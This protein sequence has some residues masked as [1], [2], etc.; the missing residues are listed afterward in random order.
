MASADV[1]SAT[2][3]MAA[4]KDANVFRVIFTDG[5]F[6]EVN[7]NDALAATRTWVDAV[8]KKRKFAYSAVTE[9]YDRFEEMKARV[10][11]G[12]VDL[13]VLHSIDYL[14]LA[15]EGTMLEPIFMPV[16]GESCGEEYEL[17]CRECPAE[18][19]WSALRGKRIAFLK[20]TCV[21]LARIWTEVSMERSGLGKLESFF[22]TVENCNKSSATILPVFFGKFDA[23]VANRSSFQVLCDLN[24]QVGRR[25]NV[26]A[27]SQPLLETVICIRPD[28][29]NRQDVVDALSDLHKEP[30]GQQLLMVFKVDRLMPFEK[31]RIEPVRNL[32]LEYTKI[33]ETKG[34][35]GLENIGRSGKEEKSAR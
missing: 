4:G 31:E 34:Q 2:D 11:A 6:A 15:G 20:A 18:G 32:W 16:K 27:A 30:A 24:P 21:N 14:K 10:T 22:G 3:E 28:Y 29:P 17:L 13:V 23:C 19:D 8:L 5:A 35:D 25:L 33:L 7:R 26:C 12:T 9:V 1:C